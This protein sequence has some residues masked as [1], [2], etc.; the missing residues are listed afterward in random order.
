MAGRRLGLKIKFLGERR[1][2]LMN[3]NF[4]A[5]DIFITVKT[6]KPELYNIN[7]IL[8]TKNTSECFF[9]TETSFNLGMIYESEVDDQIRNLM[10]AKEAIQI[11]KDVLDEYFPRVR[12]S[13]DNGGM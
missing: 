4:D 8:E 2:R 11:I 1:Q 5:R 10:L 12:D 7:V 13:Y 6:L 9:L 3:K